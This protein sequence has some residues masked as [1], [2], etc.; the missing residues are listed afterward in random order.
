MGMKD[1]FQEKAR[2]MQEQGKQKIGE[3]REKAGQ[4]GQQPPKRGPQQSPQRG[5]QQS[6]QRGQQRE[7]GRQDMDDTEQEMHDRFSQDYDA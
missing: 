4:R 7:H 5:Q 1:Q 2:G 6:P 3:A